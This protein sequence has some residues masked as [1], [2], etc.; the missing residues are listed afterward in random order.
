MLR[1]Q[2]N[3]QLPPH[4]LL[5]KEG[6]YRVR[7][8]SSKKYPV[9]YD[10]TFKSVEEALEANKIYLAKNTLNIINRN[11]KKDIGFS[12][13]CDYLLEWYRNK[14]KKPSQNTI[15]YYR[16]YMGLLKPLFRNINLRD[17]TPLQI[18]NILSRESKRPKFSNGS[19]PGETIGAHTLYH[20]YTVLR[21]ILNK[22]L[23]WGFIEFNPITSVE[24]PVFEEKEIIVPE[25]EEFDE[26]ENKIMIAPIRDRCQFL[27]C[28]FTGLRAEEI[29]GVHLE[30]FDRENL[31]LDYK[32]VAIIQNDKTREFEEAEG[33][34]K[35]AKRRIPL[36]AR[37]FK[38]L[39]E[40]LIYRKDFVNHLKEKTHGKYREINNLFL[41]KDG[42]FYRP[43][44]LS[45]VWT[46]F[47]RKEDIPLSL[48]GLRHYYITNQM[49]YN[50]ELSPRDVQELAGHADL[51]TTNRYVH[52]SKKRISRG[53]TKIFEHFSKE[54]LY[55][56]GNNVLT[57]PIEH[58]AT[59]IMG[60]S[61]YS[62]I[63]DLKITLT[64][65]SKK[66]I[67]F[68]NISNIMLECKNYLQANYPSLTRLEKYQYTNKPTEEILQN[69]TKEFGK[70]YK[71]EIN[72]ENEVEMQHS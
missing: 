1:E 24:A 60:D 63:D 44:R 64:E 19:K 29:C 62:N 43:V 9:P 26:I 18:E 3:R 72:K 58:I 61:K 45:Q 20:E 10:K 49:N 14:A 2:K 40:Y 8:K 41:N 35:N 27:L 6:T 53:A 46:K 67:D 52:A 31:F 22:A 65:L 4:I 32:N 57:I 38:V 5:T 7:Y 33:K 70:E 39:D 66:S 17:I 11:T 36:P 50:D 21:R 48:H 69:I 23:A 37:F 13:F 12:H 28:L 59:I 30:D 54:T 56:N 55:K 34:S 42:H 71:V 68:F 47:S 51:R 25:Y 15:R 16:Q